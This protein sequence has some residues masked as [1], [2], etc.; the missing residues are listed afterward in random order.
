MREPENVTKIK[1]ALRACKNVAEVN[2]IAKQFRPEVEAMKKD[3][4]LRVFA[5]HISNLKTY[6]IRV[7][8]EYRA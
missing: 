5:I 6:M 8:L 3:P 4:Q 1:D 2:A 7:E